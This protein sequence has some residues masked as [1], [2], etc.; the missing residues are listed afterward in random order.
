MLDDIGSWNASWADVCDSI[1]ELSGEVDCLQRIGNLAGEG[2]Y[3]RSS[4]A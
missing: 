4:G 1:H 2:C 3:Q